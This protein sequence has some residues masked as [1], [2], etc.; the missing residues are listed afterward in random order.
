MSCSAKF[1]EYF[2]PLDKKVKPFKYEI[3]LQKY[4]RWKKIFVIIW[5]TYSEPPF[6]G[7]FILEIGR[8]DLL[9]LFVT[10]FKLCQRFKTFRHFV[11][12]FLRLDLK[13]WRWVQ[14]FYSFFNDQIAD[15]SHES[16]DSYWFAVVTAVW[17]D[18]TEQMHQ[19]WELRKDFSVFYFSKIL[20]KTILKKDA[21][22]SYL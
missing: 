2:E 16:Y 4:C 1:I 20:K 15:F 6:F 14:M 3:I 21:L 19:K 10:W 8:Q 22:E 5:I 12:S 7:F 18:Q 11:H 9:V 13:Y 17:I